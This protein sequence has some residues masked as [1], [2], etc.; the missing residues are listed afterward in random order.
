VKTLVLANPSDYA[1]L[2]TREVFSKALEKKALVRQYDTFGEFIAAWP[3]C[4]AP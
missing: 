1:R 4:M 3:D 2:R